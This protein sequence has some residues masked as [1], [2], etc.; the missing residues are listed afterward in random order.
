ML[1]ERHS[2][3]PNVEHKISV[4]WYE[5]LEELQLLSV[6]NLLASVNLAVPLSLTDCTFHITFYSLGPTL[7]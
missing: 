5:S 7:V 4:L 3:C 2:C 6:L 1:L